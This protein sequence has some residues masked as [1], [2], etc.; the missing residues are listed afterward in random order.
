MFSLDFFIAEEGNSRSG[1]NTRP[2][3]LL[4][5]RKNA[6]RGSQSSYCTPHEG[7][8]VT[9]ESELLTSDAPAGERKGK[10][11]KGSGLDQSIEPARL[12]GRGWQEGVGQKFGREIE[13]V[14]L[15]VSERVNVCA[16]V[17]ARNYSFWNLI[18]TGGRSFRR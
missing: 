9:E 8:N 15:S 4:C 11:E 1:S 7:I 2:R 16:R 14:R 18:I 13:Y 12:M 3:R 5:Q 17:L 6:L 10:C